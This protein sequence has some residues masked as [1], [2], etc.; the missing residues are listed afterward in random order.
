M[1][2]TISKIANW[3]AM[4]GGII[5]C[6][7][8]AETIISILGRSLN[9]IGHLSFFQ[10]SLPPIA[11]LLTA[12]GP[13]PGDFELVEVGVAVAIML[14]LPICQLN[15]GHAS[16]ELL[17][18]MMPAIFNKWLAFI[19]EFLMAFVLIIITWRLFVGASDKLRYGETTFLL[20]FPVWW[21]Y[22]A[23]A[24]AGVFVCI[25]AL[26]T[27]WQRASALFGNPAVPASSSDGIAE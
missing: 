17:T 20:Q 26:Y 8:I 18:K 4:L 24:V 15:Q 1:H 19:W 23:C 12:L 21:G 14:F 25:V 27:T 16:V 13:I 5:L 6:F 10:E 2:S 7:L 11:N 22:A 9:T 3:L